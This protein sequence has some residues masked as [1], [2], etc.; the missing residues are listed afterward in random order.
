MIDFS[1][2]MIN[3]GKHI[4]SLEANSWD[5]KKNPCP[6]YIRDDFLKTLSIVVF[7]SWC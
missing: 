7:F 3:D 2:G 6:L 5:G 1:S 4:K